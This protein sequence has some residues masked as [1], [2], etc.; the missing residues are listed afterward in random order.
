[1]MSS[2]APRSTLPTLDQGAVAVRQHEVCLLGV[3]FKA[4]AATLHTPRETDAGRETS[5]SRPWFTCQWWGAPD[6]TKKASGPCGPPT[7]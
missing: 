5:T 3:P 6:V 1:M 4:N 2:S 7:G